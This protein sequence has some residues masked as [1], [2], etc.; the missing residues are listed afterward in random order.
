[1]YGRPIHVRINDEMIISNNCV[2]PEGVVTA[3]YSKNLYGMPCD[4]RRA[5]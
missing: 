4:W 1:M 2:L 3:K 5:S